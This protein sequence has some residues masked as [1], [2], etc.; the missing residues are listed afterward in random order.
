MLWPR[1]LSYPYTK[2][3]SILLAGG[4]GWPPRALQ[5]QLLYPLDSP[6]F[7]QGLVGHIREVI[8][9]LGLNQ[10]SLTACSRASVAELNWCESL[11]ILDNP[12]HRNHQGRELGWFHANDSQ[13]ST[14]LQCFCFSST[15]TSRSDPRPRIKTIEWISHSRHRRT[16]AGMQVLSYICRLLPTRRDVNGHLRPWH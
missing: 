3:I 10:T 11:A 1:Y 6:S 14:W 15:A 13:L 16:I 12:P 2:I 4:I 8:G 5:S 7:R 9:E